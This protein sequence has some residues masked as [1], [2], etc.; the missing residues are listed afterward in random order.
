[1]YDYV[2]AALSGFSYGDGVR[3]QSKEMKK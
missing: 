2:L 1:M 3:V